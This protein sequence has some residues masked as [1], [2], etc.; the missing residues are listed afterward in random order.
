MSPQPAVPGERPPLQSLGPLGF[1]S[2]TEQS[3]G[4]PKRRGSA[5]LVKSIGLLPG[6]LQTEL[7]P[8]GKQHVSPKGLMQLKNCTCLF[9]V[10]LL[11]SSLVRPLYHWEESAPIRGPFPP[12]P[13]LPSLPPPTPCF[14]SY[15]F[16]CFHLKNTPRPFQ[17]P[18]LNCVEVR[19]E[20][21]CMKNDLM[22]GHEEARPVG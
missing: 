20:V 6:G 9:R 11:M 7:N 15:Y 19:E 21:E 3:G 18:V 2:S 8:P 1:H 13:T 17:G 5:C 12:L 16:V 10:Q 4:H 14:L 22:W